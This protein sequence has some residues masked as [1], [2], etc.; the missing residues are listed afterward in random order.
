MREHP[1]G[2][3]DRGMRR[4]SRPHRS[5]RP[6]G[7]PGNGGAPG[8]EAPA[9]GP[10]PERANDGGPDART[11]HAPFGPSSAPGTVEQIG[12]VPAPDVDRR[13]PR[14]EQDAGRQVSA[15]TD[16]AVGGDL[17]VAGDLVQS[18]AKLVHGDVDGA[19]DVSA[20]NSSG[21]RTSSRKGRRPSGASRI[22]STSTCGCSPRKSPAATKPAMLIGSLAEPY[23]GA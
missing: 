15:L 16:L 13:E 19:G 21:V 14:L 17:T 12:P 9:R 6:P 7:G 20:P 18:L 11:A 3:P 2:H 5:L 8:R 4:L 23:C 10:V 22:A 1:P